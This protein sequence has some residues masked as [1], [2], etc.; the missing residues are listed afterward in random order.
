M[1]APHPHSK[2]FRFAVAGVVIAAGVIVGVEVTKGTPT[3]QLNVVYSSAP[4]LFTGAAVDVL[5]VK[6]G[7]VTNVQNVGDKVH[8]TLAVDQGTKI[9]A[10]GL[11]LARGAPAARVPR[12]RPQPGLHRRALPAV[13]RHHRAR[14][15]PP[16][17]SRPTRCS[18]SCSAR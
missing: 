14:T 10:A 11:R 4:G 16:C 1:I 3:Y 6:V 13:G 12:R 7:S 15:T 5:G 17:R 9:P 2:P 18:R 8:V